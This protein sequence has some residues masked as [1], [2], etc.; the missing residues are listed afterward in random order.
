MFLAGYIPK[1][2]S[3]TV[4]VTNGI[5]L[6]TYQ[7]ASPEQAILFS[8][9][10]DIAMTIQELDQ[11]NLADIEREFGHYICEEVAQSE[12]VEA[13]QK[14]QELIVFRIKRLLNVD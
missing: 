13:L 6:K 14:L 5:A 2:S 11:I 8:T 7:L 1:S 3:T 12:N 9:I 4:W 10:V